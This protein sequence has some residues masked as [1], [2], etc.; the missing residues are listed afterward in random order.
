MAGAFRTS[1]ERPRT[2][3]PTVR[4]L[5]RRAPAT[6]SRA[7]RRSRRPSIPGRAHAF[8]THPG[9]EEVI[10]VLEGRIEQWI[11]RREARARS[12]RRRGDRGRRGARDVQ[13]RGRS[14]AHP[15]DPLAV[16]RRVGLR[17]SSTSAATSRGRR[18]A[19]SATPASAST[20]PVAPAPRSVT[21]TPRRSTKSATAA[22]ARTA[23]CHG[24]L[25]ARASGIAEP[26]I[27]PIAAGPAPSRNARTDAF[28]RMRSKRSAP[29]R[30]NENEGANAT[31]AASAPIASLRQ[32]VAERRLG[33]YTASEYDIAPLLKRK[34]R[35]TDLWSSAAP[36][37][38][39]LIAA[40]ALS[41]FSGTAFGH[42]SARTAS[43]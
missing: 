5:L 42:T 9:Q 43:T 7:S 32:E 35:L 12:R 31:A 29:S 6:A 13:R 22:P 24:S 41:S 20:T 2:T 19:G 30:M 27:A 39:R 25:S 1:A 10:F 4:S 34:S 18:Y 14:R 37:C 23:Y 16:R 40:S 28:W 26:M 33:F 17:A 3:T 38:W 8:H 36:A 11:E 15:R 21:T